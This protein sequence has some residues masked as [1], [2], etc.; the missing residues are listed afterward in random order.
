MKMEIYGSVKTKGEGKKREYDKVN[1]KLQENGVMSGSVI[2]AGQFSR[3]V[4][5]NKMHVLGVQCEKLNTNQKKSAK[6]VQ[7]CHLDLK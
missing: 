1:N 3:N 4:K 2:K 7:G 5:H 6:I